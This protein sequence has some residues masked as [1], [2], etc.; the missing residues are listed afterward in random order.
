MTTVLLLLY[1]SG[2]ESDADSGVLDPSGL[3]ITNKPRGHTGMHLCPYLLLF[4]VP[5]YDCVS[6]LSINVSMLLSSC[7]ILH[8][9]NHY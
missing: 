9:S 5:R 4:I 3:L 1:F 2:D 7:F 6:V 8:L